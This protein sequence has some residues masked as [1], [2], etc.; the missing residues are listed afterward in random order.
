MI[1]LDF[2]FDP[3]SEEL[4]TVF[5]KDEEY[6]FNTDKDEEFNLTLKEGDTV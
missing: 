2:T 5:N 1:T 3:N 6:S 4:D